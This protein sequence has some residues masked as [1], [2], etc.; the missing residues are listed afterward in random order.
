MSA[1]SQPMFYGNDALTIRASVGLTK[2]PRNDGRTMD[3]L[4][5]EAET[6]LADAKGRGKDRCVG[7]GFGLDVSGDK[8]RR[9]G[10]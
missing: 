6:A 1:I 10:P 8:I 9:P 7:F 2:V 3:D 5:T 4:V